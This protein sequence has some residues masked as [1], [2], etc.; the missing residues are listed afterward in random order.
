MAAAP[1][2]TIRSI[3]MSQ[4][5]DTASGTSYAAPFVTGLAAL[6]WSMDASLTGA[7]VK[8]YILRGSRVALRDSA[9]GQ[10][11]PRSDIG[12]PGDYQINAYNSLTLLAQ[13]RTT[14]PICGFPVTL[15]G[16]LGAQKIVF[17]DAGSARSAIQ[18]PADTNDYRSISVAQG[19]RL[20]AVGGYWNGGRVREYALSN[21]QWEN[22][23]V[24]AGVERRV[25]LERDTV[26]QTYFYDSGPGDDLYR[27]TIRWRSGVT[28]ST[29]TVIFGRVAEPTA[30]R[31]DGEW[32]TAFSPNGDYALVAVTAFVS[33]DCWYR[34]ELY[35]IPIRPGASPTGT[36]VPLVG[37]PA[38]PVTS[39]INIGLGGA[40]SAAGDRFL[41]T[42]WDRTS[43]TPSSS[44]ATIVRSGHPTATGITFDPD[45]T[46]TNTFLIDNGNIE[47]AGVLM[48]WAESTTNPEGCAVGVRLAAS[49]YARLSLGPPLTGDLGCPNP[50]INTAPPIAVSGT[51]GSQPPRS[52]GPMRRS[53]VRASVQ[54]N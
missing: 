15:A 10:L 11:T 18:I 51:P 24:I 37:L 22:R 42:I 9:T 32:P 25:Y 45:Q 14:A 27:T 29:S 36:P 49:P 50:V 41:G 3:A 54:A 2:E 28:P 34:E 52:A 40:W 26:D 1:G 7:Q 6:Q 47:P 39:N 17:E 46:L 21:G 31:I 30:E 19:G 16:G 23:R 20:I 43:G 33:N 53:R 4:S 35:L 13:E 8:D 38:C 48:R 44:R 12:V 5:T